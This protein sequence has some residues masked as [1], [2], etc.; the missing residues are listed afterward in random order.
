MIENMLVDNVDLVRIDAS[1]RLDPSRQAEFGQFMTPAPTG[2]LL[3]SMFEARGDRIRLLDPGAGVGSLTAAWVAEIAGRGRKPK[4]VQLTAYEVDDELADR[5]EDTLRGCERTLVAAGIMCETQLRRGDFIE[6]GVRM[7]AGG[8]FSAEPEFFDAIIL[9][10]PYRKLATAS[11]ERSLLRQIGVDTSNLYT[12]FLSVALKLLASEG[13]VVA[14][15][16][17]SFC[18]GPY[19]KSFR[20]LLIDTV[21]L[22]RLHVFES[23]NDAFGE[24]D[25][26]Q[27]N[28]VFHGVKGGAAQQV[29]IS[30]STGPKDDQLSSRDVPYDQVVQPNDPDLFIHLVGDLVQEQVAGRM[31]RVESRLADLNLTVSTGRVV[32]F[33]ASSFLRQQP[34]PDT[35]PLIYPTHFGG[36][37]VRWPKV[38]K[39]PNAIA[40]THGV[41]EL[42]VPNES[43][44]LVK[45][46]SAKEERRRV[47]AAV[48]DPELVP[49]DRVGFENHLNYFHRGG[50]GIP[51]GVARGLAVYLNS[52]LVDLYFRQFNGHTQVNAA[53]L[54]SL[55]YPTVEQLIRLGAS[56]GAKLSDQ[57][58]IDDCVEQELFRHE[59]GDDPVKS[60]K[61]VKDAL[62][63]L[64]MLG[65]PKQQINERSALTLLAI[66]DLKPRTPWAKARAPLMGIT[67]M[68]AFFGDHYGKRYKPN[69][70]ETVRRQT[71][72]QFL[73]AGLVSINPD[74]PSRPTNSPNAVYQIKKRALALLRSFGTPGW[75]GAVKKY[76]AGV[77]TLTARYE[78]VRAMKRIPVSLSRGKRISLSPGGQN[79][80]VEK[81]TDEF[82][83]RFTPGGHVIYVGDT[84]DKFAYFDEPLLKK[85]G[86]TIEAHGKMPDVVI[87]HRQ[88]KWLVLVEAVTSH[89]PVDGKRRGE[90]KRLFAGARPGLVFVTAFMDRKAMVKHLGDISWETEVWIADAPDHLIHFNGERFL[91]PYEE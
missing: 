83:E 80:L 85:L 54:R 24:E 63:I 69:T 13:E 60:V 78:R 56:V 88:K 31:S 90:L 66:L 42:L 36:G 61:K 3:A 14:I 18:N 34:G 58:L 2:R 7:L 91:G 89:G 59:N 73:D 5:L 15:T 4:E 46:F 71:V 11:K 45:R 49:G 70:R 9:N 81:I 87:Y 74:L 67:P 35:A 76:L 28:I 17:R 50:R 30:S 1:R 68:M 21:R 8:F 51:H 29:E 23:R 52:T 38:S 44:V 82:C 32:D 37:L 84:E 48:H 10:P 27:E 25:V 19:F 57:E 65:F 33:R 79:V 55:R 77:Q 62:A 43:Y 6:A 75:D 41:E 64:R 72:H 40:L 22:R 26:L 16:P 20:R 39:K 47:V 12:A 53:D 86:V